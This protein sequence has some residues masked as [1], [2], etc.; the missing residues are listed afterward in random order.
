MAP[1]LSMG[2]Q[3]DNRETPK[4]SNHSGRRQNSAEVLAAQ[5]PADEAIVIAARQRFI[6][7][8]TEIALAF[9]S[10]AERA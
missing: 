2:N 4:P 6:E 7:K 5:I 3:P 10:S 9:R 8:T 1:T